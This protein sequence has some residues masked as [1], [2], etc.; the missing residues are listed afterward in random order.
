MAL[1]HSLYTA[2]RL[3][4]IYVDR[5]V[6]QKG[7]IFPEAYVPYCM[8]RLIM[9]G[10]A[11]FIINGTEV[12]IEENQIVYIP[13]GSQLYCETDSD[14]F[15]F[16]SIRFRLTAQLD[17]GDFLAEYYHIPLVTSVD[18]DESVISSFEAVL[19]AAKSNV[20]SKIFRIR[21]NLEL[22][23][24]WLTE[25]AEGEKTTIVVNPSEL[26]ITAL[27]NRE[28]VSLS[29]TMDP[30]ITALVDYIVTNINRPFS[31]RELAEMIDLSES[32]MRRLF[33]KHTGKSPVDFI[34]DTR[35]IVAARRLLVTNEHI[36]QIAY[37]VGINDP[38]YFSRLFHKNYGMSPQEY[39]HN[40]L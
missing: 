13:Q 35:L 2:M 18:G 11:L 33:R 37:S 19:F 10:S 6:F 24:A 16:I 14:S 34:R 4:F 7:W 1:M 20:K 28:T 9:K 29:R 36:A 26:S 3:D 5:Y 12:R 40:A 32:S 8:L 25:Q 22:I 17:S 15:D 39:R 27:L 38:N 30:R 31:A 21:G 23:I